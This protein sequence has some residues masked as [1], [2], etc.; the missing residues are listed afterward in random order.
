MTNNTQV[1]RDHSF[2]AR[3][4]SII[5]KGGIAAIPAALY[6]YQGELKLKPQIV[7][8]VSAILTHKW[9]ADLPSPS[10]RKMAGDTGVSRQQLH[11]YKTE[12]ENDGWLHVIN[13]DNGLGGKDS[14]YYDFTALFARLE[15]CLMRDKKLSHEPDAEAE[16]IDG[17]NSPPHVNPG[18]HG[19]VNP[20]LHTHDNPGLHAHVN[21]GLPLL[22]SVLE[23]SVKEEINLSNI[24]MHK[25]AELIVDNSESQ[26]ITPHRNGS[27][28]TPP[29]AESRPDNNRTSSVVPSDTAFVSRDHRLPG[30]PEAIGTVLKRGRGRPPKHPYSEDRQQITAYIQD[31]AREMG[32]TAPLKSSVT[33]ADNLYQASGRSIALFIDAMYQARAKTKERTAAIHGTPNAAEPFAP[34]AKMA[35]FFALLEDE[36]GMRASGQLPL[37]A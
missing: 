9:D 24:R 21:Q 15:A 34:K 20:S 25:N 2:L 10:L 17:D 26:S 30:D 1:P 31:F 13:R 5:A 33:R 16:A 29:K 22:E 6:R 28:A 35:Y 27:S 19:H 3:Y 12:L 8:F 11:N 4:G 14:N 23:E 36:L 7:R 37:E 32:D 18:L